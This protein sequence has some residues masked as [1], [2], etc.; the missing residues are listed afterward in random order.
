MRLTTQDA[1]RKLTVGA[2]RRSFPQHEAIDG[3][4]RMPWI[5]MFA[6]GIPE[7]ISGSRHQIHDLRRELPA[8]IGEMQNRLTE[9]LFEVALRTGNLLETS[10]G[11]FVG[12]PGVCS[13]VRSDR[14]SGAVKV[15]HHPPRHRSRN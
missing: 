12:E 13:R 5:A 2:H 9:A 10:L 1:R 11:R 15:T 8:R 7:S 4:R 14:E 3:Q 6:G